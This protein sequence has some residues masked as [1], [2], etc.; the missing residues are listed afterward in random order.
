MEQWLGFN[1]KKWQQVIDVED[2]IV[3]NYSEY[4]GNEDFLKGTTKKTNK[5]I[6]RFQKLIE[7]EDINKILDIEKD[8]YS[9]IDK[10]E[11]GYLDR[12][13][14]L[15]VGLQ[16]DEPLKLIINPFISLDSSV[17]TAK[18]Y[19]YR[20]NSDV[21]DKFEESEDEKLDNYLQKNDIKIF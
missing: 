9:G 7:K 19:G 13:N 15:I 18:N 2:F 12:R 10:F 6:G 17:E 3:N 5:L 4:T 11:C 21:L 16:T 1:G 8:I 20:I 14:E